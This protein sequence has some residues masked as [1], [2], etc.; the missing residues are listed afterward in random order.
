MGIIDNGIKKLKELEMVGKGEFNNHKIS[1][2]HSTYI[3]TF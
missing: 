2:R 3:S 1:N